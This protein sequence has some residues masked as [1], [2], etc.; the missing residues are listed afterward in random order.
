MCY[1]FCLWESIHPLGYTYEDVSIVHLVF[2]ILFI[3]EL[4]WV[5]GYLYHYIFCS[6]NTIIQVNTFDV[7]THVPQ[8]DVGDG[9]VDI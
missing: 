2:E 3:Y 6:I 9:A 1:S 4:K 7:H 5:H 8:F